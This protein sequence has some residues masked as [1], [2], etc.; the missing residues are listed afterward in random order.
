MGFFSTDIELLPS[1]RFDAGVDRWN[2]IYLEMKK[3]LITSYGSAGK[4]PR[5]K[6]NMP[7][8]P[9]GVAVAISI[10][11]AVELSKLITYFISQNSDA[12]LVPQKFIKS[13]GTVFGDLSQGFPVSQRETFYLRPESVWYNRFIEGDESTRREMA[14]QWLNGQVVRS[15]YNE[16]P[17]DKELFNPVIQRMFEANYRLVPHQNKDGL[18]IVVTTRQDIDPERHWLRPAVRAYQNLLW[19][20][21]DLHSLSA[22]GALKPLT[23]YGADLF[24]QRIFASTQWLAIRIPNVDAAA[25]WSFVTKRTTEVVEQ[26]AG[27]AADALN[28]TVKTAAGAVNEAV[29][30]LDIFTYLVIGS[31]AAIYLA[32]A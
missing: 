16:A 17:N 32:F 3:G 1:S 25:V 18:N 15:N 31:V 22:G 9:Y 14:I 10:Q 7:A 24:L 12:L 28:W 13:D 8:V 26:T 20:A 2:A 6:G 29:G 30:T 27:T 4:S 19:N 23:V 11:F 21:Y 5:T